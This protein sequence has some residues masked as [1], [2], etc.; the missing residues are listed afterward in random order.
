MGCLLELIFEITVEGLLELIGFCYIKL[1]QLIVPHKTV[2]EKAKRIIK[3]IVTTFAALVGVVLIV[4]LILFVQDDP[5]LKS[6]GKYM[7]YASLAIMVLQVV[8]GIVV[9]VVGHFKK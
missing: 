5:S 8:S 9:K 1:M 4:G 6:I 2:S 7:T 3:I